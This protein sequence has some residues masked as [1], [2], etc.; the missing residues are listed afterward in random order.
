MNISFQKARKAGG[1][2]RGRHPQL[3]EADP[4]RVPRWWRRGIL[5]QDGLTQGR[6]AGGVDRGLFLVVRRDMLA[7]PR[8]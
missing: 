7:D 5:A 3:R 4:V 1:V 8:I 6:Q 2:E